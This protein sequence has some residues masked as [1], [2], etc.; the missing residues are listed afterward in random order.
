MK[1]DTALFTAK[2]LTILGTLAEQA[3]KKEERR[4]LNRKAQGRS[5]VPAPGCRDASLY[6]IE[7][8]KALAKRLRHMAEE[9][10]GEEKE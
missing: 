1:H 7:R 5:F 10:H 3:A 9:N 6:K 4:R 8:L 2:E